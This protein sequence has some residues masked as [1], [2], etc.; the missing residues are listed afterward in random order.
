[1]P[2]E[3]RLILSL[4]T[5]SPQASFALFD[6]TNGQVLGEESF[7]TDRSHNSEIFGPLSRL[8][9]LC[10]R[11]LDLIATGVG[12]GSYSGVRVA[13]AAAHGLSLALGCPVLGVSSLE[14]FPG[15][16][17]LVAGDARRR[18]FFLA[19]VRKKRLR[20]DPQLMDEDRL[21]ERLIPWEGRVYTTDD[22]VGRF[23]PEKAV[24][25]YPLA[26][27]IARRAAAFDFSTGPEALRAVEPH[28]LRPPYIT[29]A[30]KKPV[31][32]F[33]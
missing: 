31:P 3:S 29:E 21:K 13:I 27:E 1:M 10:G 28:Y 24:V 20:G 26:V 23:C 17:Y 7:V 9:D 32:G 25:T 14:A 19:E 4:E 16:A 2:G 11:R 15:E 8:L 33:G 12:P 18:S 22:S 30:K 6:A 5:S